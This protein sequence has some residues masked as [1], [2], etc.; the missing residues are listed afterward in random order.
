MKIVTIAVSTSLLP[1]SAA[2]FAQ[3]EP[4]APAKALSPTADSTTSEVATPEQ[5]TTEKQKADLDHYTKLDANQDG[6]LS[7][8]ECNAM[9][10]VGKDFGTLDSDKDGSLTMIEFSKNKMQ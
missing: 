2:A 8:A 6:K 4:M 10:K 3:G 1:L 5:L 7:Q 9:P